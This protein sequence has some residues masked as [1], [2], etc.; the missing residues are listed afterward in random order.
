MC[1]QHGE[2]LTSGARCSAAT[3]YKNGQSAMVESSLFI[4]IDFRG[5]QSRYFNF[6]GGNQSNMILYLEL[7]GGDQ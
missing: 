7:L 6:L 3:V 2:G 5:D 1:G 4:L